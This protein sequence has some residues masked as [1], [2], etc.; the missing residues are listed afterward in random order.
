MAKC[1]E[2]VLESITCG[3]PVVSYRVIT[4]VG[5]TKQGGAWEAIWEVTEGFL[6]L[7]EQFSDILVN[8]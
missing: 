5:K 2:Y 8:R 7:S 6:T 3:N 1:E 4:A